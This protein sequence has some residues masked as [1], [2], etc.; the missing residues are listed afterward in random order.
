MAV[1]RPQD[2]A[3]AW[4]EALNRGDLEE[5]V[6]LYEPNATLIPQPGRTVT[7]PGIRE[8]LGPFLATKPRIS[9][10]STNIIECDGIAL[11]YGAWTMQGTGPDGQPVEMQGQ[12]TEVLRRQAD[13]TWRYLIDDPYSVR[14]A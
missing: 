9:L 3:R 11:I 2:M 6:A 4:Q 1:K 5:L 7:G 8:A 12:S 14:E 13:G 10:R